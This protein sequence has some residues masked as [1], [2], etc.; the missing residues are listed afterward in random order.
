MKMAANFSVPTLKAPETD[1]EKQAK[2][3][4]ADAEAAE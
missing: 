3:D 4:K 2:K 1:E